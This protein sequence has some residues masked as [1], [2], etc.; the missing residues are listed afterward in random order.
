MTTDAFTT[1]ARAHASEQWLMQDQREASEEGAEWARD[2][3]ARQEATDA[4]VEAAAKALY[5]EDINASTSPDAWPAW[6]S[7]DNAARSLYRENARAALTAA[8]ETNR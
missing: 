4:E 8:K 3:L 2:Y 5:A 1:A 6:E 7:D